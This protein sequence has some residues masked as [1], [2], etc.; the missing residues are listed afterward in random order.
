MARER[1]IEDVD[2]SLKQ[3]RMRIFEYL[4]FGMNRE[5]EIERQVVNNLLDERLYFMGGHRG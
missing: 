2:F 4:T 5:L 3:S 1:T